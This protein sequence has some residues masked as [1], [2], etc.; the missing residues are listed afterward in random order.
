MLQSSVI[1]CSLC[2]TSTSTMCERLW[3]IFIL[4]Y[5][6][7]EQHELD[8]D[9]SLHVQQQQQRQGQR[10][11]AWMMRQWIGS[12][13]QLGVYHQL[14]VELHCENPTVVK[15]FMKMA[16]IRCKVLRTTV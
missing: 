6:Q 5:V 8:V 16:C 10:R 3:M 1:L 15:N 13:Q 14:M 11:C 2:Y 12:R 9:L 7:H 4:A